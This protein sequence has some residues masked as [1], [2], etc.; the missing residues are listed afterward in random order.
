C[1]IL[2][3]TQHLGRAQAQ[4]A[5]RLGLKPDAVSVDVTL[6]GGGFGRR[7]AVDYALEAAEVSRAFGGPVQVVWSRADDMR[8]G[9][10]HPA[11]AHRMAASLDSSGRP[12]AWLHRK[13]GSLLSLYPPSEQDLRDPAYL[14]DSSWGA[15]DVPYAIPNVLT[16]YRYVPSPVTSG[17]WRAVYSPPCTFA[18]ESFL[19]ELAH[20]AG[21]D[22]LAYRLELLEG[23]P[24]LKVGTLTIDR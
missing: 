6:L 13:A 19:D 9:P 12:V 24:Q 20:A 8:H 7:L 3:P 18:R 14:Q 17:P 4:V 21:R 1:E 2:G 22:P 5:E 23:E 16:E 10:F 15:Y 11:S